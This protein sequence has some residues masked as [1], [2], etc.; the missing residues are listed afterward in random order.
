M[1]TTLLP[2]AMPARVVARRDAILAAAHDVFLDHGFDGAS[3]SQVAQRLGGSKGT[4]YSYFDSKEALFEAL[5]TETCARNSAA[6]FDIPD[7]AT[8]EERLTAYARHYIALVC[9]DWAIRML[10]IIAAKAQRRP[11]IGRLFF[12]SGPMAAVNGL[13]SRFRADGDAGLLSIDDAQLAAEN[14]SVLCRGA[15]HLRRI[16]GL[17][18][19]PD[20]AMVARLANRA[21]ADFLAIYEAPPSSRPSTTVP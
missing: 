1:T 16:L 15:L 18:P 6:I 19:A 5:V 4:L 10:C 8:L 7:A 11:A 17:A 2:P 12:E 20:P 14:F 21:V 3:M 9:S 13:A